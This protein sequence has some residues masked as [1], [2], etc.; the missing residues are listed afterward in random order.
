MATRRQ[1][2]HKQHVVPQFYLRQFANQNG[3]LIAYDK[4]TGKSFAVR[5]EDAAQ[6]HGFFSLPDFDGEEGAGSFAETHLQ[7]YEGPAAIAVRQVLNGIRSGVLRVIS[8]ENRWI[9]SEFLA[10]QYQRTPVARARMGE[11]NRSFSMIAEIWP[12]VPQFKE[13][14]PAVEGIELAR[15]H[16][17]LGLNPERI[18]TYA[19]VLYG[20]VWGLLI[21]RTGVPF[22]SSDSP[23]VLHGHVRQPGEGIGLG[24]FGVEVCL[25]LA[26]HCMLILLERAWAF[27]AAPEYYARDAQVWRLQNPENVTFYRSIQVRD[28]YRFV[29][30]R[31]ENDFELAEEMCTTHPEIRRLDRPR[32]VAVFAGEQIYPPSK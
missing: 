22:Y 23:F 12:D 30:S 5:V 2:T 3:M 4:A 14:S 26:P 24:S 31:Q 32:T 11:L 17:E 28:A 21:N 15:H 6:K 16:L 25:P 10:V 8:D 20:H 7:R 27:Q 29:Y 19:E 18:R 9:L 13:L 1:S